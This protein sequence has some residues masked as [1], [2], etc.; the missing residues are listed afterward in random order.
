MYIIDT[1]VS[2]YCMYNKRGRDGSNKSTKTR[3]VVRLSKYKITHRRRRLRVEIFETVT[4]MS[5]HVHIII[6][7]M[8][9]V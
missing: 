6:I 4:C 3:V 7:L 1:I 5:L 9:Y 2:W 8:Y